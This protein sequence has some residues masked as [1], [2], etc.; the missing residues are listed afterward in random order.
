MENNSKIDDIKQ[1]KGIFGFGLSHNNNLDL[2]TLVILA[3]SGL[4]IQFFFSSSYDPYGL[5]GPATLALWGYGLT[6]IAIFLMIF[7]HGIPCF[8]F[9]FIQKILPK[10]IMFI[11]FKQK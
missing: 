6:G 8:L 5:N 9:V 3:Y 7:M 4:F 1:N 10:D 2:F 11:F